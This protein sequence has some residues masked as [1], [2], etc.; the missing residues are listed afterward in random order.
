MEGNASRR[1]RQAG[2]L[3]LCYL[4]GM[5]RYRTR[6]QKALVI[7]T[8]ILVGL[9]VLWVGYFSWHVVRDIFIIRSGKSP[10]ELA[11]QELFRSTIARVIAQTDVKPEDI[12]RIE[13]DGDHP[14]LGNPSAKVRIVEFVDYQC[15]FSKEVAPTIRAFMTAHANDAYYILRDYPIK[16]VHPDAERVAVSAQ[17]VFAQRSASRFWTFFDRVFSSQE[18]QSAS[19]L[20]LYAA[21]TGVDLPAYDVCISDPSVLTA[22]QKSAEDA[23]AA[24]AEGTPTFF[25]NGVKIQG[26][27]DPAS[28]ESIFQ[29]AKKKAEK[30]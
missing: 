16:D 12:A 10:T 8:M 18:K 4:T 15:P 28:L 7:F 22:I 29:E 20:R 26:A 14:T 25:F 24:G 17:C 2:T 11:K 5:E 6:W 23:I 21:Q 27:M 3:F 30:P 13:S 19:D 9:V 1:L